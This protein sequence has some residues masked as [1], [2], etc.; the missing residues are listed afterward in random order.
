MKKNVGEKDRMLRI[1]LGIILF[2][3]L[4]LTSTPFRWVGLFSIPLLITGLTRR[5]GVYALL[6]TDTCELK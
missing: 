1:I 4:F 3:V 2:P 6:G 5:C